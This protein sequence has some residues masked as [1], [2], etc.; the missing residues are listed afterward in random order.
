M[1][2][3]QQESAEQILREAIEKAL[4]QADLLRRKAYNKR[5]LFE[6]LVHSINTG[7]ML[8]STSRFIVGKHIEAPYLN[9]IVSKG[10][11]ES[12]LDFTDNAQRG[13]L[14]LVQDLANGENQEKCI[15]A[16]RGLVVFAYTEGK[17]QKGIIVKIAMPTLT[18]LEA[19]G[20]LQCQEAGFFRMA[21]EVDERVLDQYRDTHG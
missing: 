11:Y 3:L 6:E 13:Y 8:R 7:G 20:V 12:V 14:S 16:F 9:S 10:L 4:R 17:G 2:V 15:K 5:E 21:A 18:D 19:N 1:S